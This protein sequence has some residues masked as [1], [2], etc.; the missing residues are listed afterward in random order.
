MYTKFHY[1]LCLLFVFKIYISHSQEISGTVKDSNNNFLSS[2][3][4]SFWD[5]ENKEILYG[6]LYS[7]EKGEF[8]FKLK[9]NYTVTFVEVSAINFKSSFI[10]IEV[11]ESHQKLNFIL[12]NKQIELDEV[13]VNDEKSIREK[14]DTVFY[15][16]KKFLNGSER[17]I[18][19]L[20]KKLPGMTVNEA[21]GEIKYKGKSIE[22][23]KLEGDDLFG[24]NYTLG[25][26]NISVDMVEQVQA[27][28][29]YSSNPLLKG[30]EI[31]DKVVV[32]LKIK[33]NK[34][35]YSGT[36]DLSNGVG[37][38]LLHNDAITLL[39]ISKKI[40]SFGI[41]SFNN[42]GKDIN[43]NMFLTQD[44]NQ[45]DSF[46]SEIFAKKNITESSFGKVLPEDRN[47]FNRTFLSNYNL[48]Y[49]LSPRLSIK[50]NFIFLNDKT[51]GT[52]SFANNYFINNNETIVNS[53]DNFF[54]NR[55]NLFKTEAKLIFNVNKKSLFTS[56][57]NF[58]KL[59]FNNNISTIQNNMYVFKSYLSTNDFVFKVKTEYTI[60]ISDKNALQFISLASKNNIS[61]NLLNT[62]N[63]NFIT[64]KISD[65]SI[66]NSDVYKQS[67]YNKATYLMKREK[68][69]NTF[70][71]G[72][73]NTH[74]L[75]NSNLKEKNL[76][77]EG[78]NNNS[79][80][81]KSNLFC[82]YSTSFYWKNIKLQSYISAN[83]LNQKLDEILH[84]S[85]FKLN[86]KFLST[87][88]FTKHK[89][90]Y[91]NYNQENRTPVESFLFANK[92]LINSNTVKNNIVSIDLLKNLYLSFGYKFYSLSKRFITDIGI[93][94]ENNNNQFVSN[95]IINENFYSYT[96]FQ[97]STYIENKK[98]VLN[99]EKQIRPLRLYLKNTSFYSINNYKNALID[100]KIRDNKSLLFN[101]SL[102]LFSNF[103]FILNFENKLTYN[104][105]KY[106]TNS[107]S[108]NETNSINNIFKILIRP[109]DKLNF[110]L[111]QDYY[112]TDNKTK[113][114]FN[115]ID[116]DLKYQSSKQKG[117]SFNLIGRNLLNN[118]NYFQ[119]NNS[120]F[121]T[122]IY[123]SNLLPR[124]F[125]I[126]TN[127]SF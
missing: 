103:K 66:Q 74:Q 12:E 13:I 108:Q 4:V 125:L 18:E 5:S 127:L 20:I 32:N 1:F 124:Y 34:N 9:P 23:V 106:K 71:L 118:T 56:N 57:I 27:I 28:E 22:T 51:K 99:F 86:T 110:T 29:N 35:N 105:I 2:A 78:F 64:G 16:P 91:L 38:K 19:D 81:N 93:L 46:E 73:L 60:K 49:K 111:T 47:M 43:N 69:Y 80:Y 24:S 122:S 70:S 45:N 31:S 96:F 8:N 61:Q 68:Y 42:F 82:E 92:V 14:K 55:I 3:S 120:D 90:L 25:T 117:L 112:V 21:T 79:S 77:I 63:N 39:G 53:Q 126:S 59:N 54:I 48:I 95:M 33:K 109:N 6:Y 119:T 89:S 67:F 123:K 94:Y 85:K 30:I 72:Y 83:F 104:T 15:N 88:Y 98:I 37:N 107:T 65:T 87:Y 116:F 84:D 26:K 101:N 100:F 17:K 97:N 44:F 11:I 36:S 102:L 58:L 52:E 50:N 75:F 40:K 41:V 62:P 115:F 76:T 7:D 114:H 113:N 121:S 10:K